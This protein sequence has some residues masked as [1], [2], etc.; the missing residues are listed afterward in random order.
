MVRA[1]PKS[2][3]A[4][5]ALLLLL[6]APNAARSS[7]IGQTV[8][9][10]LTDGGSL[11]LSQDVVVGSGPEIKPGDGSS[12]GGRLLPLESVEIGAQ[13][14][15][16][17]FEEGAPGGSS[18]FPSGT[19]YT[20]SKLVFFDVPTEIVG[21]HVT[22]TNLTDL[23]TVTFTGDSVTVP[24]VTV[25]IVDIPPPA[26]DVGSV[27]IALDVVAVPE[28][29]TGVLLAAAILAIGC[30]RRARGR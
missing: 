21:I 9:V 14:I 30:A 3:A 2:V 8:G 12:I 27:T 28:P 29:S 18:G 17:S 6:L 19:H 26:I 15:T 10:S 16:L 24:V 5:T 25:K 22:T 1:F 13:R 4:A 7:L 20:F 23:G 11:S